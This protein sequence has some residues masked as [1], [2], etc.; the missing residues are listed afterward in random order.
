MQD[1]RQYLDKL[2]Q[3]FA[4]VKKLISGQSSTFRHWDE[5]I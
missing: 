3:S 4:W 1:Q 2:A 5:S